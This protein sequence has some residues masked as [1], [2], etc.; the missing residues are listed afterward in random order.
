MSAL[1]VAC[2]PAA[3]PGPQPVTSSPHPRADAG[4]RS[5]AGLPAAGRVVAEVPRGTFGP[6]VGEGGS[7]RVLVWS[8]PGDDT[9]TGAWWTRALDAAG[10]PLS[11]PAQIA[12]APQGLGL[13]AARAS[14]FEATSREG[15]GGFVVIYSDRRADND[16]IGA[17]ELDA[18]GKLESSRPSLSQEAGPVLWLDAIPMPR[19]AL[20][21]WARRA[22]NAASLFAL[23]LSAARAD[24]APRL[25]AEKVRAW[26]AVRVPS[27]AAVASVSAARGDSARGG[28][29]ELRFLDEQGQMDATVG[30]GGVVTLSAEP[31]AEA[32]LDLVRYK[33][34]LIVA[35]TDSRDLDARVY[36]S[37]ITLDGKLSTP[38]RPATPPRGNQSLLGLV[39]PAAAETPPYLI[40]ENL[41]DRSPGVRRF[42]L[43]GLNSELGLMTRQASVVMPASDRLPELRATP[44]GLTVLASSE[45]CEATS[46]DCLSVPVLTDLDANLEPRAW[47]PV[48]A[49][50]TE[51]ALIAWGLNCSAV[52]CFALG[53][54]AGS[55]AKI[56]AQPL[57]T[58]TPEGYAV[59]ERPARSRLP[60]LSAL[61]SLETTDPLSGL[62]VVATD[63]GKLI[64]TLTYFDPAIPYERPTKPAPDGRFAPVRALLATRLLTAKGLEQRRVISYRARSLGG[65]SLA[66]KGGTAA[67]LVWSAIDAGKPQVFATLLDPRGNKIQQRMITHTAG[68]VSDV[69][70]ARVED[71][72]V[73]AWVDERDSDPEVYATK[74]DDRLATRVAEQ[75]ITASPGAATGVRL[76]ARGQQVWVVWAD[77]RA[78]AEAGL[79]DIYM[80]RLSSTDLAVA[81]PPAPLA[82]TDPHSHS[83]DLAARGDGAIV[84]WIEEGMGGTAQTEQT[85]AVL[86][87]LDSAGH[88]V[89]PV[90]TLGI[91]GDPASISIDCDVPQCRGLVPTQ[92]GQAAA[93]WGLVWSK[94][95][96]QANRLSGITTPARAVVGPAWAGGEA[97][98]TDGSEGPVRL[99]R[100]TAIWE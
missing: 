71:G 7:K 26:Q 79:A 51:P 27:G 28:I 56:V 53:A 77:A 6:Y 2:A 83:A 31:S 11:D 38:P 95:A 18:T 90:Q 85:S 21:L 58:G 13:V 70:A 86:A 74:L 96:A 3:Q 78:N 8:T 68:D 73:L 10:E 15:A 65:V 75:R 61:E 55:P 42:Q 57:P 29:V 39:A 82:T 88:F 63:A 40:W 52:S 80:A 69:A 84:A 67:L 43:G 60:T 46:D 32:E 48:M 20:A 98:F 91:P 23:P 30:R 99:R 12:E 5:A 49:T 59:V 36:L 22:D 19:G 100:L 35:W 1:F 4:V 76:L 25:V 81:S 45:K 89:A 62:D 50:P 54:S 41:L 93:L 66:A 64:A 94:G 97:F 9:T 44:R 72:W 92:I 17:L 47:G 24:A 14:R 37:A 33:D 87:E 34:R 16:A